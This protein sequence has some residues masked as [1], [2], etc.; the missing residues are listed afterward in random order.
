[1]KSRSL[2]VLA[3]AAVVT[4]CAAAPTTT[5]GGANILVTRN[6]PP[7]NCR[8]VGEVLGSQGN[9]WTAEF[10]SD[11][12][13]IAGARNR[14][15]DRAFELGANFVQIELENQSHNTADYSSGGVYSSV[16]MGNAYNCPSI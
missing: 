1:M 6:P 9:F 15:R 7:E 3:A 2:Q 11:K 16:I 13:L 10:T 12:D 4:G 8:Y 14:M 5:P